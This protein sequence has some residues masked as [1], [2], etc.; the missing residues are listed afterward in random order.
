VDTEPI[1]QPPL[2]EHWRGHMDV[3]RPAER[4]K[5][6]RRAWLML[7][8]A[9]GA[10]LLVLGILWL[11]AMRSHD[12]SVLTTGVSI[13]TVTSLALAAFAASPLPLSGN[14]RR[15]QNFNR[16]PLPLLWP[17]LMLVGFALPSLIVVA[18][19]VVADVL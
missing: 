15:V 19:I 16:Q 2:V 14:F 11:M 12:S 9:L 6:S 8:V 3:E 17:A 10:G 7:G 18:A 1:E 13:V 4:F 5:V